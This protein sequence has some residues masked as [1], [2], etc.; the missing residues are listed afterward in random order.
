[1]KRERVFNILKTVLFVLAG[2][3]LYAA[4]VDLFILPS[5][6]HELLLV[7]DTGNTNMSVSDLTNMVK[8]VN[9]TQLAPDEILSDN[10]YYYD[11]SQKKLMFAETREVIEPIAC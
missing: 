5:S 4:V 1:M 11:R 3:F 6:V 2:N 8:E 9:A 7:P 10:V